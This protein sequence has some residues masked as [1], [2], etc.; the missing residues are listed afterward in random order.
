MIFPLRASPFGGLFFYGVF[1]GAERTGASFKIAVS[2]VVLYR[3]LA[4]LAGGE[5]RVQKLRKT[6]SKNEIDIS[7]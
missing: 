7:K 4:E 1:L 2:F 6:Y 3:K 5:F